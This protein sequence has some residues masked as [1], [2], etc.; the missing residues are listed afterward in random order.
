[1]QD[2]STDLDFMLTDGQQT[3]HTA[4]HD[5]VPIFLNRRTHDESA[6]H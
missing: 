2:A 4:H 6:G 5:G 3:G 1:M